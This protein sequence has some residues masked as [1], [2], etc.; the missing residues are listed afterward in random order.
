MTRLLARRKGR[1]CRHG[2]LTGW[3]A[4]ASVAGLAPVVEGFS[5]PRTGLGVFPLTDPN[6]APFA[7]YRHPYDSQ[8][9]AA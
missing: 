6:L 7:D 2:S 4:L 5:R 9:G 1:H 8:R 3:S